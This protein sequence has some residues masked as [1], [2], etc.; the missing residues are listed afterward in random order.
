MNGNSRRAETAPYWN[1]AV[2]VTARGAPI[3]GERPIQE[4]R[5]NSSRLI[6]ELLTNRKPPT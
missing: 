3:I 1:S 6:Y 5:R 4:A 2:E